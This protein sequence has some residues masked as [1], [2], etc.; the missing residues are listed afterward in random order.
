M[1]KQNDGGL[2]KTIT[3]G[4]MIAKHPCPEWTRERVAAYLGKGKT[5]VEMLQDALHDKGIDAKD[6][7]WGATRFLPDTINRAFAIWC[8]RQCKT[9]I[10][11]IKT[12]INIIEKFYNN[13]A[14]RKELGAADWTAYRAADRVAGVI[15]RAADWAAYWAAAGAAAWTTSPSGNSAVA[16]S[17]ATD[18]ASDW[19]AD[20][21][22]MRKKQLKKLIDIIRKWEE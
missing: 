13:E 4:Q 2:T 17:R 8:A 20:G 15:G 1:S 3:V 21:V 6:A 10:P 16:A 19:A 9:K 14:T 11:E 22:A 5:Q 12:Y 18:R 7:I